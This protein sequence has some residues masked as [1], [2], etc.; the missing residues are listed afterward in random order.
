MG[1][2][3]QLSVVTNPSIKVTAVIR[4]LQHFPSTSQINVSHATS[5]YPPYV[6]EQSTCPP[7]V[8]GL[9]QLA[10]V[11]PRAVLPSM[12][13]LWLSSGLMGPVVAVRGISKSCMKRVK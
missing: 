8:C 11:L 9:V 1:S 13:W 2:T 3:N 10:A 5:L 7:A 6:D 12:T 4:V